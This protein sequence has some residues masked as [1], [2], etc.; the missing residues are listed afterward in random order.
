MSQGMDNFHVSDDGGHSWHIQRP[1]FPVAAF[2]G[3]WV[4]ARRNRL[5]VLDPGVSRNPRLWRVFPD[6]IRFLDKAGDRLVT[7]AGGVIYSAPEL[8]G[9]WVERALPDC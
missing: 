1:F 6:S 3:K 5:V 2:Q 4:E 7:R 8:D 9:P